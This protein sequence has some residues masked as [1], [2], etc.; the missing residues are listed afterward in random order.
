MKQEERLEDFFEKQEESNNPNSNLCPD[1]DDYTIPK[2]SPF[3]LPYD[4]AIKAY[5]R[6]MRDYVVMFKS[7]NTIN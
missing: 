1:S 3:I 7:K 5:L 6:E 2:N 4:L